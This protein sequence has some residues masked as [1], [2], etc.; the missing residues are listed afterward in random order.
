[1]TRKLLITLTIIFSLQN[2]NANDFKDSNEPLNNNFTIEDSSFAN[3]FN[4][5]SL[6]ETYKEDFDPLE[7]YNRFM[8]GFNDKAYEYILIPVSNGYRTVTPEFFRD[9]LSNVLDNLMFPIR[10]VNNIL[11]LKFENS[12]I[13]LSRFLINSTIGVAGIFDVASSQFD[14]KPKKEDLGQTLGHYGVGEGFHLVLPI[15]GPSNLRDIVGLSFDNVLN[16][17]NMYYDEKLGY[18]IPD[19]S[20]QELIYNSIYTV[21]GLPEKMDQY[22]AVKAGTID[23]Y[24]VLKEFYNKKREKEINE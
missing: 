16:P 7:G 1:M 23:I 8:T 3:E 13:E 20:K 12:G 17:L 4:S 5:D 10:F 15:L 11:Q 6:V 21:N 18:K 19:T 14:L 22:E 2:L 9:G 24:P